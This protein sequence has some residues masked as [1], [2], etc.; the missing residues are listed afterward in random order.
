LGV[1]R[2]V[3]EMLE[4]A[5]E[6]AETPAGLRVDVE[7]IGLRR[8]AAAVLYQAIRDASCRNCAYSGYDQENVQEDA[9]AWLH[10]PR[11]RTMAEV[12]GLENAF[13]RWLNQGGDM[14]PLAMTKHFRAGKV[15]RRARH[16]GTGR[17]SKSDSKAKPSDAGRHLVPVGD[18]V[19]DAMPSCTEALPVAMPALV[20]P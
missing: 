11:A 4:E 9:R 14:Q 6:Q 12:A 3:E 5:Q 16:P 1:W 18:A 19:G 13:E 20:T 2:P 17:T 10:S 15:L 7:E 8:L